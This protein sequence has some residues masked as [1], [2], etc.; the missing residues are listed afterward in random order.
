MEKAAIKGTNHYL[1]DVV[2]YYRTTQ[3]DLTVVEADG[4]IVGIGKLTL[5]FDGS[6]WLELLRVHPDYQRRGCGMAIYREYLRQIQ[7]FGCPAARM[8][9]GAQNIPSASLAQ[10]NGLHRGC[11]FHGMTLERSG[12]LPSAPQ[13]FRHL[14][15]EE[16]LSALLPLKE[17]YQFFNIN[18]TYY[19]INEA[20]ILGFA[21]AGWVYGDGQ[22]SALVA[23]CRFQPR[24]GLYVAAVTGDSDAALAYAR[25]LAALTG[26]EKILTHF[27]AESEAL[28]TLYRRHGFRDNPSDLVVYQWIKPV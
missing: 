3:G 12:E 21:A 17:V 14:T 2:D 16:A 7:A 11:Q 22:G 26:Q 27:P 5:L 25:Y 1:K 20:T 10:R 15:G 9:T 18:Q 13:S 28:A 4:R 6:A 19:E 23:G 24:K 8:Y